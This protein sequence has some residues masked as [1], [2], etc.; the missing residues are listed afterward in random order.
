MDSL[1]E[2]NIGASKIPL[3]T[4][5]ICSI[6]IFIVTFLVFKDK[7]VFEDQILI[8]EKGFDP[9]H[10]NLT[11]F[12]KSVGSN[13]TSNHLPTIPL[14][15]QSKLTPETLEVTLTE[16]SNKQRIIEFYIYKG[17]GFDFYKDC[18][19]WYGQG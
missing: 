10:T 14:F 3:C 4:Y 18:I 2:E 1:N 9:R 19:E 7:L 8:K 16:H 5:I 11:H 17:F 15:I 6:A 12:S 13:D